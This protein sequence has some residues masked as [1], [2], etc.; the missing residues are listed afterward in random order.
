MAANNKLP[1][2]A[3]LLLLGAVT[4]RADY[5]YPVPGSA[6]YPRQPQTPTPSPS[7][8]PSAG[9]L[10][11]GFYDST[12]PSAEEIVRGVVVRAVTQNPG[13][14]AGLIR[15]LFHDCFVEGCDASVLLDPTTANPQPE[16]LSPPNFPSLRGFEVVDAAKAAL[17]AA[18]PRTVS[19]A[20]VLSGGRVSFAMPAGRRDGRVSL[21]SE[22]LRFL[23]PPSFNLSQPAASFA[24]KGLGVGDLVVLSGA[25][26][27]GVSHCSSFVNGGRLNASTSDMNPAL[28]ASLRQQ[29][30][31]SPNATDDPTVV[32]DVVTPN[33]LDS[34]YYKNVLARNV[35]FT[36]DDE[37]LKSSQTAAA[38]VLNAF[39][40]GL[41][42]HKFKA[43]MVKMANIQVKTGTNGEIRRNCRAVN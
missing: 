18:C 10:A 22:A 43:A 14:G 11:V 24:A 41:W 36:S 34:Q 28:A 16:K 21:S 26:T 12:C 35:L 17:E 5:G 42:E 20:D 4:C 1:V 40:P 37:L 32:Q 9:V 25:H 6:G 3:L 29:C 7:P 2:V 31:A 13:V 15:M 38:V 23:P 27:I 19:C 8:P 39:V 33:A 30:P